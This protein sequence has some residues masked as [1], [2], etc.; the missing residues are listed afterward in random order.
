MSTVEVVHDDD[1][2]RVL[3]LSSS[4]SPQSVVAVPEV[5]ILQKCSVTYTV[6]V[7]NEL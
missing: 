7:V 2:Y 6:I 1:R 5:V 4:R 3:V